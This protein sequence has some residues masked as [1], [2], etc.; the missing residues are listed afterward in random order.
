MAKLT[1]QK[2]NKV[3]VNTQFGEKEKF[4]ILFAEKPNKWVDSFVGA[5]NRNFKINDVIEV[6]QGRWKEPSNP[7]HNWTLKA[8]ANA[9][10]GMSQGQFTTMEEQ[11]N[12]LASRVAGLEKRMAELE[13]VDV[14]EEIPIV[15]DNTEELSS[16]P[17]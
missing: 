11:L 17:F 15:P 7:K 13:I 2:I 10:S 16:I 4:V 8:P 6:E 1:I 3:K 5:W 14:A 12:L 9:R